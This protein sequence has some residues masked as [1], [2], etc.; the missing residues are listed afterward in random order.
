MPRRTKQL[1]HIG[2]LAEA[3]R[4]RPSNSSDSA[5]TESGSDNDDQDYL[6]L[7][8]DCIQ[9]DA[10]D[11]AYVN[12]IRWVNGA[13]Q[14]FRKPYT[15]DSRATKYRKLAQGTINFQGLI[16]INLISFHM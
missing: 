12:I 3:K 11:A 6:I 8:D 7:E 13:G 5:P 9:D 2:K 14:Q 16:Y 1:C 4:G 15:G 10:L